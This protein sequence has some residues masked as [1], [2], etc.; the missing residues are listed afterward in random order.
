MKGKILAFCLVSALF[1][2]AQTG[3]YF[4]SHFIPGKEHFNN[5]V[6]FDIAQDD[7]GLFYFAIQGGVLRFDGRTWDVIR[8]SGAAYSLEIFN[9]QLYVAGSRGFGRIDVDQFGRTTYV[10]VYEQSVGRYIF[11]MLA[12]IDKLYILSDSLF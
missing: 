4:L 6:C 9:N 1:V 3:N 2:S 11:L 12:I 5:N 8:T 7:R 10:P